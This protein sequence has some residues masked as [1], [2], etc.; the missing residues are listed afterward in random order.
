MEKR[1][2]SDVEVMKQH[3]KRSEGYWEKLFRFFFGGMGFF[4]YFCPHN[5][6]FA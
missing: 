5:K 4:V 1:W 3:Q 6:S 2:S